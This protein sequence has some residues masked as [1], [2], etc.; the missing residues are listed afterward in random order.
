MYEGWYGL[1]QFHEENSV[2][3]HPR[4]LYEKKYGERLALD[5]SALRK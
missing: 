3:T 5:D 2:L 4:G 1:D